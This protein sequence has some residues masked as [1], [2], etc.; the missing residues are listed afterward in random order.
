[1]GATGETGPTGAQGRTGVR[2]ASGLGA[3]ALEKKV[4]KTETEITNDVNIVSS[5]K[6]TM[7]L[8]AEMLGGWAAIVTIALVIIVAVIFR[9]LR[10]SNK[11]AESA[12]SYAS[13]YASSTWGDDESFAGVSNK[14]IASVVDVYEATDGEGCTNPA[15]N[16]SDFAAIANKHSSVVVPFSEPSISLFKDVQMA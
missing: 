1:V 2:G 4:E 12:T 9:R 3:V 16:A 11:M 5:A 8:T 14:D 7:L 13:S 15:F 10:K 6:S